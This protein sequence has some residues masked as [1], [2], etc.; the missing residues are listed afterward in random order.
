M[1][2]RRRNAAPVLGAGA[3]AKAINRQGIK[4]AGQVRFT[5]SAAHARVRE[6]GV[7][8]NLRC[9][10]LFRANNLRTTVKVGTK[11]LFVCSAKQNAETSILLRFPPEIRNRIFELVL[12]GQYL[13]IHYKP[14]EHR[15]RQKNG[16]RY[17]EHIK[18]GWCCGSF[19]ER[20]ARQA[21]TQGEELPALNASPPTVISRVCR[22]IYN[23]TALCV[24]SASI[25]SFGNMWEIK[26]FL[27]MQ[28]PIQRRSIQRI[29]SNYRDVWTKTRL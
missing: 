20:I 28:R 14:H 2:K 21:L 9:K 12:G 24:L 26:K 11:S 22:Q 19:P 10:A 18:G 16:E 15:W 4:R 1:P 27:A 5:A 8:R 3:I 7:R 17:K 23:E 13:M 29:H 25:L 6:R